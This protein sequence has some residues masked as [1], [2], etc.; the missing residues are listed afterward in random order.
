MI[1]K[2]LF[3][4]RK[5]KVQL[6]LHMPKCAGSSVKVLLQEL[7]GPKLELDYD[8]YFSLPKEKR[9]D[10]LLK[11]LKKPSFVSNDK[12][13]YGHFFPIKYIGDS[14]LSNLKL[15]T[16]LRDPI[17]RLISHY[18]FWNS[19]DFSDHYLWRK[20]ISEKWT[21]E[22]FI[23]SNEMK[24]F[25]SQYLSLCPIQLFSYIGIFENLEESV[26]KCFLSLG[27]G[28]NHTI[29]LPHINSSNKLNYS[30]ISDKFLNEAK[31]FHAEDY[32]IYNYARQK[33]HYHLDDDNS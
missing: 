22:E 6:F 4:F 26:Q 24:N 16:I 29:T 28:K 11:C 25:Y 9:S 7:L 12:I 30:E 31:S 13:I 19:N 10:V 5:K 33:F 32:I 3:I 8:S 21:L 27:I 17:S 20:M 2:N 14:V 18:N 1:K 23:M 15:V